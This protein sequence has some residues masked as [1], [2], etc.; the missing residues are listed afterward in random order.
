MTASHETELTARISA[1]TGCAH[2]GCTSCYSQVKQSGM[3][4]SEATSICDAQ[5]VTYS[6]RVYDPGKV[7]LKLIKQLL[8]C[9]GLQS[10]ISACAA[11]R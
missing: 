10:L 1:M 3:S 6:H 7:N 4:M 5:H 2:A 11:C 9:C 8:L